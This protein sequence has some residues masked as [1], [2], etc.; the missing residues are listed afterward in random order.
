MITSKM[1]FELW[2]ENGGERIHISELPIEFKEYIKP[3]VKYLYINTINGNMWRVSDTK[4]GRG[5]FMSI[6]ES[7]VTF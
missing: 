6:E 5:F 3:G 7:Q 4:F 1:L 2:K